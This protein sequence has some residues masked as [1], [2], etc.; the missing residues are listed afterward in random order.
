MATFALLTDKQ[1]ES[2]YVNVD[3]I[4]TIEPYLAEGGSSYIFFGPNYF[5]VVKETIGEILEILGG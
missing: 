3:L 1:G 5:K 4:T 2:F